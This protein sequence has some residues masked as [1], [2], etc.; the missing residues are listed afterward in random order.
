MKTVKNILWALVL[1]SL[2]AGAFAQVSLP[3][4]YDQVPFLP[5][6]NPPPPNYPFF[7][8]V[9][10][11]VHKAF[12]LGTTTPINDWTVSVSANTDDSDST[13]TD[14]L[15]SVYRTPDTLNGAG[16]TI[17]QNSV[18]VSFGH[19]SNNNTIYNMGSYLWV[20][21]IGAADTGRAIIRLHPLTGSS[22]PC[23]EPRF[24]PLSTAPKTAYYQILVK[25]PA[26]F[27]YVDKTAA[28]L[29]PINPVAVIVTTVIPE[30]KNLDGSISAAN[31][32][33]EPVNYPTPMVTTYRALSDTANP[34]ILIF[35]FKSIPNFDPIAVTRDAG[36]NEVLTQAFSLSFVLQKDSLTLK[37]KKRIMKKGH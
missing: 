36:N 32:I 2:S 11:P 31:S 24:D 4:Q 5:H 7:T 12:K 19:S 23:W 17:S 18:A 6:S 26:G 10:P 13:E 22:T 29:S 30:V 33:T 21:D 16:N 8:P 28:P 9:L 1:S 27:H 37:A 35:T 15:V 20:Q 25:V 14:Y 3:P 34:N